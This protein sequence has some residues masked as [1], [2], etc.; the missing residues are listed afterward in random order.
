MLVVERVPYYVSILLIHFFCFSLSIPAQATQ[1]D[2]TEE[3]LGKV[4]VKA[5]KAATRKNWSRAIKHGEIML[6]G[7][8][9]LYAEDNPAYI[10][11]LK[12]LNR[13]YDKAGRLLEIEK[14]VIKAYQLTK[15]HLGPNHHN[16][17]I[18][19]LLYYKLLIANKDFNKAILL[20]KENLSLL[21]TSEDDLFSQLHYLGQLFSLY[22]LTKQH[23]LEEATLLKQLVLNKKLLGDN[24]EDSLPVILNLA[25]NYCLQ[26]KMKAYQDLLQKYKLNHICLR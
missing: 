2:W 23:S 4:A 10:N 15:K 25:K 6:K 26:N 14:R 18:S 24:I 12:T 8:A 5:D 13:Y 9:I 22:G 17:K 16:S 19:R 20:V 21:G 1:S 7:S 11:R 3:R